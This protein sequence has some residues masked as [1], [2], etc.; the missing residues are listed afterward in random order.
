MPIRPW[1]GAIRSPPLFSLLWRRWAGPMMMRFDGAA[2]WAAEAW[3]VAGGAVG[4][5]GFGSMSWR[6]DI[7]GNFVVLSR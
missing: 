1:P 3:M 7:W 5:E 6:V 2:P 4:E